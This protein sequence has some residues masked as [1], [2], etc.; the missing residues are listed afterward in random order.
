MT[1]P[2]ELDGRLCSHLVGISRRKLGVVFCINSADVR[3][4]HAPR[5]RR[6]ANVEP[7]D[8]DWPSLPRSNTYTL[9]KCISRF[10]T[11]EPMKQKYEAIN[12]WTIANPS[13]PDGKLRS[14]VVEISRRKFDDV[15]GAN[16]AGKT[17]AK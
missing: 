2:S 15:F 6:P 16:P 7:P 8:V 4:L 3:L 9:V 10:C 12:N 1:N 17:P 13:E 14:D 5:H 11:E